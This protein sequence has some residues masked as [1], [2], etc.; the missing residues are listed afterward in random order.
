MFK[1]FLNQECSRIENMNGQYIFW[2]VFE[3]WVIVYKKN[4]FLF[5]GHW[6]FHKYSLH[7]TRNINFQTQIFLHINQKFIFD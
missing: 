4:S 7:F 6:I 5:Y 3:N 1:F 2:I